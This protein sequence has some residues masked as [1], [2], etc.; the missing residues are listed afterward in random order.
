MRRLL[1]GLVALVFLSGCSPAEHAQT[2]LPK[3][4]I[5]VDTPSGPVRI[6]VD[7]ANTEESRRLGLM[8][9]TKM[10]AN[11]GM[12]FDFGKEQYVSFWMKNTVLPLDMVFIKSDGTVSTIAE[13]AVPYSLDPVP[14]SEPVQAVLEL[15][16]GRA[17][18]L[19]I[20]SGK[21]VHAKI[22]GTAL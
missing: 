12:L 11:E 2:G 18:A 6:D 8:Y 20:A 5:V 9:R 4:V 14:S 22:F 3:A 1:M 16:A 7:I 13:N 15:N 19:G 10:G 21:K 17:R